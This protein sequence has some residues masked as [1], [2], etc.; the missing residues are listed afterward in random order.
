M[1]KIIR[2]RRLDP[3]RNKANPMSVKATRGSVSGFI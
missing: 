2:E 3:E 1:K